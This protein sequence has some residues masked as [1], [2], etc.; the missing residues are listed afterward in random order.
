MTELA[1]P[2]L[3]RSRSATD[4]ENAGRTASAAEPPLAG[5]L[6]QLAESARRRGGASPPVPV[7]V[8][9]TAAL[10][11]GLLVSGWLIAGGLQPASYSPMQQTM[12]VMAGQFGTD[13]WVMTGALFL[14]GG[15]QIATGVGLCGVRMP[16][17]ILLILT[18]LCTFGVAAAPEPAT[19]PTTLHLA[20]AVCCVVTTAV[21]PAFAV[22]R[23][24]A[25]SWILSVY[26][27][28][29]VMAVF[30]ALCGWL[31][32]ATQGGGDLGLVERLTS[33]AQGAFPLVVALA[34]RQAAR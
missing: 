19:G 9:V 18:G 5:D 15:C 13:P 25:P 4:H 23:G 1:R 33:S 21:W 20:F 8:V 28:V 32:I 12:S 7:W 14:V 10:T 30:A 2:D 29:T 22:F 16:A 3:E 17:R 27:C 6:R 24:P 34:L 26:G 11:P 31:L